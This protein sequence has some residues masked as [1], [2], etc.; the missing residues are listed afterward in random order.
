MRDGAGG[1]LGVPDLADP[2]AK[3][4]VQHEGVVHF[5]KGADQRRKDVDRDEQVRREGWEVVVSTAI[6]DAQPSRLVDKVTRAY[7]RQA[8][9]LGAHVLPPHLR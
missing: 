6:D 7:L 5:E 9:L 8:Q 4:S 2:A 3:V 1:W